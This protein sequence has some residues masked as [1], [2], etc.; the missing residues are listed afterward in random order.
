MRLSHA[1][2]VLLALRVTAIGAD[3]LTR[4][5][6]NQNHILEEAEA[7]AGAGS[8]SPS[9]TRAGTASSSQ[10]SWMEGLPRPFRRPKI[11]TLM[12]RSIRKSTRPS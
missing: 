10:R 1:A 3:A 6:T 9:S 2:S 8:S 4:L 12:A 7:Q 11:L 5:D